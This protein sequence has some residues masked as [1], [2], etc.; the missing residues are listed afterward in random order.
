M[1]M[2]MYL[3]LRLTGGITRAF[4]IRFRVFL[5]SKQVKLE[6]RKKHTQPAITVI[7]CLSTMAT[8][9]QCGK[10]I[11]GRCFGWCLQGEPS[12]CL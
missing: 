10:S 5:A 7:T 8:L 12:W 4:V 2:K 6:V 11:H 3:P 9:D 1:M